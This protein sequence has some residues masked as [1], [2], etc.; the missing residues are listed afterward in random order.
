[1]VQQIL[2]KWSCA[3]GCL[4][5]VNTVS[6]GEQKAVFKRAWVN[7]R[8][9]LMCIGD[10]SIPKTCIILIECCSQSWGIAY[11]RDEVGL[12]E[13]ERVPYTAQLTSSRTGVKSQ[14]CAY[15]QKQSPEGVKL[16]NKTHGQVCIGKDCRA[17]WGHRDHHSGN[18]RLQAPCQAFCILGS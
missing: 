5:H 10:F 2:R 7:L 6:H 15:P 18:E 11:H 3:I 14:D 1:M 16:L 13:K 9:S 8:T 4:F 12:R 17:G